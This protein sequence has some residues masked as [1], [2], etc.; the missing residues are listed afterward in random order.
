MNAQ[1]HLT[2][3]ATA[4]DTTV[5]GMLAESILGG[6]TPAICTACDHVVADLEPDTEDAACTACGANE[7]QSIL[8]LAHAF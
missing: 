7:V 8:V 1:D 6:A 2:F 4:Q 3:V 5:E